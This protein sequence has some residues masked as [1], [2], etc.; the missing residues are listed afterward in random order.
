[1][2]DFPSN[3]LLSLFH[4]IANADPGADYLIQ[5]DETISYRVFLNRV[6]YLKREIQSRISPQALIVARTED[7]L[8]KACLIWAAFAAERKL[9]LPSD[10]YFTANDVNKETFNYSKGFGDSGGAPHLQNEILEVGGVWEK[11]DFRVC[12]TGRAD[13]STPPLNGPGLIL[14]TGGTGGQIRAV[15][16]EERLILECLPFILNHEIYESKTRK[17]IFL[18]P[19]LSHSYG[20]CAFLEYSLAGWTVL[21]PSENTG[22]PV[23]DLFNKNSARISA[24]EGVPYFYTQ[25]KKLARKTKLPWLERLGIGGGPASIDDML[26]LSNFF[27]QTRFSLRYGLTETFSFVTINVT[28]NPKDLISS[29]KALSHWNI[30]ISESGTKMSRNEE[31]EIILQGPLASFSDYTATKNGFATGDS[32]RLTGNEELIVSGRN[33][34]FIKN[35]GFRFSP[36]IVEV[37]VR[38]QNGV[39]DCRVSMA[40]GLLTLEIDGNVDLENLRKELEMVLPD[41]AL[42]EKFILA[43]DLRRNTAGKLTRNDNAG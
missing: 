13:N 43:A 19:S 35:R 20:L 41:Y 39:R 28:S 5:K 7:P 9:I 42:P 14:G 33:R 16:Y 25:F 36:E 6:K 15:G 29:G 31:G 17:T 37:K 27:P 10:L 34:F 30:H 38:K 3:K 2:Q 1:M 40:A 4:E 12:S 22:G 24:I 23:F 18:T 32:G 11:P 26:E 8:L 21:L